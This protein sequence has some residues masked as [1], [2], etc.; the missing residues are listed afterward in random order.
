M[1]KNFRCYVYRNLI[2]TCIVIEIKKNDIP[3]HPLKRN[4]KLEID[5]DS[6]QNVKR[7]SLRKTWV[8]RRIYK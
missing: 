4:I 3:K 5:H 7:F 6:K 2:S 8:D 1:K